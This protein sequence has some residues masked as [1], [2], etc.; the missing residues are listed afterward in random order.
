[1]TL[2]Q[3]EGSQTEGFLET[4][5]ECTRQV[6]S[7]KMGPQPRLL[8]FLMLWVSGVSGDIVMTQSPS[9][10]TASAGEKVTINCKSSQSVLYSSNQKSYLAWYQQRPGQSPRLLIYYASTRE[11]GVPDRFSGSGS[12]T[13]FT[14]TISSFQPE[15]AAVYYCQQAYSAPSQ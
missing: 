2:L 6:S 10:V 9:S 13:D 7:S 4:R 15:D 12:T 1:M 14:L 8:T 3:G 5:P 11:S